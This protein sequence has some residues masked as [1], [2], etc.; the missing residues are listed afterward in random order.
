MVG[1]QSRIMVH[2]FVVLC[3]C[4]RRLVGGTDE[5]TSVSVM[6]GES[7]SLN[8]GVT[9]V[10]DYH[11]IQWRFGETLIAQINSL[12]KSSSTYDTE[13]DKTLK[14]RLNLDPQTG[15]LTITNS[16][17]TDSGLYTLQIRGRET[18]SKSFRITVSETTT[19]S[20]SSAESSSSSRCVSSSCAVNNSTLKHTENLNTDCTR[21]CE[22][23]EAAIRLVVSAVV[24]VA[25]VAV[26]VY[27]IRSTRSEQHRRDSSLNPQSKIR[28]TV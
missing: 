21:C 10:Q 25:S 28:Q 8:T 23:F 3:L 19:Q 5:V 26:L 7:V 24:G 1:K 20:P 27:D 22:T 13:D 9:E 12:T 17:T 6:E 2:T 11:L 18:R 4:W 15:S 14:N 16:R